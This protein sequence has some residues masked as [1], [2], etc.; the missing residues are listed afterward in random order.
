MNRSVWQSWL[1]RCLAGLVVL[2]VGF[3]ITAVMA[4]LLGG[5]GDQT[6]RQVL[7]AVCMGLAGLILLDL[8][9][10]VILEALLLLGDRH[11]P[12]E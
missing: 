3:F 2:L 8:I 9:L 7:R 11:P 6:G 4:W 10:L 1:A 12:P 5:M